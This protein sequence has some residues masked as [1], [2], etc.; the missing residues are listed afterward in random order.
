MHTSP[1]IAYQLAHRSIRQFTS[2]AL[3]EEQIQQLVNV[4]RMSSTSNN[5][6]CVSIIR[7]TDSQKREAL[8]QYCS[9]QKYVQSA[10]EFW[11]FCMDFHKHKQ[12]LPDAQIDWTEVLLIGGIDAGIMAQNV[13]VAAESL[14]LGGVYIGALRNHIAEVGELLTLP[15]YTLPLFGLCLGYPDQDPPLKP[16]LPAELMF[17]EN[18]YQPLNRTLLNH[19]DHQ[20]SDYY[21]QRSQ[22]DMDWSRNVAK[23]L[24]KPVRP[25][26]LGYLQK[27]GFAKK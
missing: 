17:F 18:Q 24:G 3:S 9:H 22:Q 19:Y 6:Q 27:Q 16:R 1:T 20:V 7:V 26:V 5:L 10:A 13:L 4:A 21:Q 2:Q 8:K 12:I 11:V 23:A 14:E 25:H 15:K